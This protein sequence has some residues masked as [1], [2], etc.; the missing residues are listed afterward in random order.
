[1]L[2]TAR[3]R[4]AVVLS[5]AGAFGGRTFDPPGQFESVASR[6]AR[7]KAENDWTVDQTSQFA[8]RLIPF[9]SLNPLEPYALDE[10]RR[11]AATGH[12]GL[13]M[14][15][16]ES[17]VD[18]QREHHVQRMREV[19]AVSNELRLPILIH[20][21]NNT[22]PDEVVT[23][24][25]DTFVNTIA[26]AAPDVTI[27]VAHL[28]GGGGY[29]ET[30]LN[31]FAEAVAERRPATRNM[32]FD[33]AEAALVASEAGEMKQRIASN[34]AAAIRRIGVPRVLFGSD[35][36]GGNHKTPND[37]W[38]MFREI[39]PLTDAEFTAIA[40]NIAPYLAER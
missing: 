3:I 19:F 7:V 38:Q 8:G 40:G 13:K 35:Q 17:G 25:V 21:A 6:H 4:R 20:V 16:F 22:G 32:Y 1:M 5:N 28:W 18:L 11:C 39:V 2:D 34:V 33:V 30:A 27:Q 23:A 24:N 9:C 31:R 14:Q 26:A 10:L 12:R 36:F 29:S 15:L 37:A